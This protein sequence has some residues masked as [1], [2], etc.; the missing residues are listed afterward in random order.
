[1][2]VAGVAGTTKPVKVKVKAKRGTVT[3]VIDGGTPVIDC[4]L[5]CSA[6]VAP[7]TS[8]TLTAVVPEGKSFLG[9]GGACTGTV[10]TC[11]LMPSANTSVTATFSK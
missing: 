7:L 8:V 2:A 9:W 11:T 4:G 6:S 10:L 1:M 3:G 5:Q